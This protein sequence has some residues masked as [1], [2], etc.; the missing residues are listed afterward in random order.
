MWV[1][2]Y[3]RGRKI[4]TL[5]LAKHEDKLRSLFW[6]NVITITTKAIM[7][8]CALA[9]KSFSKNKTFIDTTYFETLLMPIRKSAEMA[10]HERKQILDFIIAY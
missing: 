10:L 4:H 2:R 5:N 7:K 9:Q 1:K 8:E 6:R 3:S